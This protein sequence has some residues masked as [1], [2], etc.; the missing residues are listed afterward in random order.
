MVSEMGKEVVNV[1]IDKKFSDEAWKFAG[2]N[3]D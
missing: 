1:G 3:K 2:K